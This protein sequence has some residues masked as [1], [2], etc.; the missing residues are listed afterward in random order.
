MLAR[1]GTT[2]RVPLDICS[3]ENIYCRITRQLWPY[4]DDK[5]YPSSTFKSQQGWISTSFFDYR[6]ILFRKAYAER[7]RGSP[8]LSLCRTRKKAASPNGICCLQVFLWF[9]WL[10]VKKNFKLCKEFG[11]VFR[12]EFCINRTPLRSNESI[13]L[14]VSS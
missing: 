10:W 11:L 2:L 8:S 9:C 6:I 4:M 14:N 1:L 5:A 3:L 12:W 7:K 13:D